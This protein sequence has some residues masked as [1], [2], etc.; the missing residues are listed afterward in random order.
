MDAGPWLPQCVTVKDQASEYFYG[1]AV[2]EPQDTEATTRALGPKDLPRMNAAREKVGPS[3]FADPAGAFSPEP[4]DQLD[5]YVGAA[6]A[7]GGHAAAGHS[8][9]SASMWLRPD[10]VNQDQAG[11]ASSQPPLLALEDIVQVQ[12][13]QPLQH[14]VQQQQRQQQ[15]RRPHVVP[16]RSQ[17]RQAAQW[18][19]WASE[20]Y[21]GGRDS[22]DWH[23]QEWGS[24]E[25]WWWSQSEWS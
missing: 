7:P 3:A 22:C 13:Q 6:P 2:R 9:S 11:A 14:Q 25:Q 4:K 10:L 18:H 19:A 15:V 16:A 24:Q 21:Y 17:Y 5:S 12:Q 20:P 23:E 8:S 1:R